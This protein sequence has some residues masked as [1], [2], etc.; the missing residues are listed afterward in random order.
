MTRKER[1]SPR[2]EPKQERSQGRVDAISTAT[3][4][5]LVNLGFDRASTSRIAETAGVSI[6]SL[7]QYFPNKKSLVAALI[8]RQV[9]RHTREIEAEITAMENQGLDEVMAA[10]I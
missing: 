3:S 7:Y 8:E 6:G 2:K 5:V 1:I 9:E 4:R 10:V